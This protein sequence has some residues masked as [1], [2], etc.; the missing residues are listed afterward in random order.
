[1]TADASL[2]CGCWVSLGVDAVGR[3]LPRSYECVRSV[4]A[5][6][7]VDD[8]VGRKTTL[9][10]QIQFLFYLANQGPTGSQN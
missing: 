1:M 4:G 10:A 7:V 5:A 8:R 3:G 9:F 6:V 2:G